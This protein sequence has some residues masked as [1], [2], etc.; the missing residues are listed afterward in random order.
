MA[1]AVQSVTTGSSAGQDNN[2]LFTK[3]SG[4]AVGD[5][6]VAILKAANPNV[7]NTASGW[8]NI[9]T[10][11]V[12]YKVATSSDVAA[13]SFTFTSTETDDQ[14]MMGELYRITGQSPSVLCNAH[15][16][17]GSNPATLDVP[18]L[19]PNSLLIAIFVTS[20]PSG[21]DAGTGISDYTITGGTNP[22]WTESRDD[23]ITG[24]QTITVTDR[25]AVAHAIYGD[26]TDITGASFTG[27]ATSFS[28]I[29]LAFPP[30]QG[31]TGTTATLEADGALLA[32]T[33][34]VGVSGTADGVLTDDEVEVFSASGKSSSKVWTDENPNSAVWTNEIRS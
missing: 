20:N 34:S 14:N 18:I 10:S 30:Q 21:G 8:T 19:A 33:V 1:I 17:D 12:Q 16:S 6:M 2:I 31:V 13:S 28:F 11:T 26:S 23:V 5:L 22:T 7:A 3:P 27:S 25:L 15:D 29:L 32:P 9:G 24:G 4:L